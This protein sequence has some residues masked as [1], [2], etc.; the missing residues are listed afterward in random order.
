[1]LLAPLRAILPLFAVDVGAGVDVAG[2]QRAVKPPRA[3][4]VN[5]ALA[6]AVSS[7]GC[8]SRLPVPIGFMRTVN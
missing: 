7:I 6:V 5:V 8:F 4:E 1:M 3:V 2:L